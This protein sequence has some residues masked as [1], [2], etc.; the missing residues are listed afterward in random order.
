MTWA[1]A[2]HTAKDVVRFIMI[3]TISLFGKTKQLITDMGPKIFSNSLNA[4]WA[5]SYLKQIMIAL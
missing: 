5:R 2:W 3:E 1:A 4:Y